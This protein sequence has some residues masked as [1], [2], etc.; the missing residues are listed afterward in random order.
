MHTMRP[1]NTNRTYRS[2]W[3]RIMQRS[4]LCLPAVWAIFTGLLMHAEDAPF[5]GAPLAA[6]EVRNPYAR[7]AA[8]ASAGKAVYWLRC[9]RCHGDAGEGS[10]NIPPLA[11][12]PTQKASDGAIFWYITRGDASSGMPSWANLTRQ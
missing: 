6:Q 10:G 3:L 9:A 2:P 12:G 11:S 5:H 4:L 1:R 8:A 7:Q